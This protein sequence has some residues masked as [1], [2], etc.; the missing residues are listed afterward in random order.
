M[1][2]HVGF[3][4]FLALSP[5][6]CGDR[7]CGLDAKNAR[8]GVVNVLAQNTFFPCQNIHAQS[9]AQSTG[10]S[11]FIRVADALG[12]TV[13]AC[14][15][16]AHGSFALRVCWPAISSP[17]RLIATVIG[18][19]WDWLIGR[20]GRGPGCAGRG[21]GYGRGPLAHPRQCA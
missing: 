6:C 21:P 5:L 11:V 18:R 2:F 20:A 3:W 8:G 19:A 14:G 10:S 13:T 7:L 4:F 17:L 15:N 9:L 1:L 16:T 12:E